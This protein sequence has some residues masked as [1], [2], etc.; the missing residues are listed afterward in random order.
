MVR[1]DIGT[2]DRI[3]TLVMMTG[4]TADSDDNGLDRETKA[5]LA[6]Y[7]INLDESD[8]ALHR[9]EGGHPVQYQA[10]QEGIGDG[11]P[12]GAP[13]WMFLLKQGYINLGCEADYSPGFGCGGVLTSKEKIENDPQ[14]VQAFVRAYVKAVRF[15][16]ENEDATIE[17]ML[18]Y[19]KVW[20]VDD[21]AI[22]REMYRM[23][24]PYWNERI[25]PHVVERLLEKTARETGAPLQAMDSVLDTRFLEEALRNV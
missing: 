17:V 4:A 19:S 8:I 20:G 2:A 24:S 1:P 10:L 5:I 3:S 12:L 21:E 18:K 22:A 14:Q 7:N 25:D 6:H 11:A 9:V 13:Y 15:C 16:R 23:L